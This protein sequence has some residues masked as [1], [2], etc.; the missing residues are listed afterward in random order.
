MRWRRTLHA[1]MTQAVL[2]LMMPLLD[3]LESVHAAGF[4]HRDIKPAN[5]VLRASD[6]SPVLI[7]FGAARAP[8]SSDA[9]TVVIS[10]GY[11]PPEQYSRQG[12]QGPW[13]DIYA[14]GGVLYRIVTGSVPPMS[15]HRIQHDR[16]HSRDLLWRRPLRAAVPQGDR[17][18]TER[19]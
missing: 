10:H 4:L 19:G 1:G 2:A 6:G 5:I 17:P 13:T 3:G 11:G 12:K 7:D 15:L 14:L 18:G 9:M 8:T 16:H